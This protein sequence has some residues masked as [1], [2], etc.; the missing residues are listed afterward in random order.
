MSSVEPRLTLPLEKAWS[1]AARKAANQARAKGKEH[2]QQA[3]YLK[4]RVGRQHQHAGALHEAAAR[5]YG[6]AE[7]AHKTEDKNAPTL[8]D[9][10][11]RASS[12]AWSNDKSE[13]GPHSKGGVE[14][15]TAETR[16]KI[17]QKGTEFHVVSKKHG[18]I[19]KHDSRREAQTAKDNHNGK[20]HVKL[21]NLLN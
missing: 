2:Q 21:A 6:K 14:L 5:A 15:S 4:G 11:E 16:A 13:K 20:L 8:T 19:S 1:A 10:A 3:D 9:K 18:L 12:H 17:E 7:A